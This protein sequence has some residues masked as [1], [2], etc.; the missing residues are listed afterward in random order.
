MVDP[1]KYN[2]S[3][4]FYIPYIFEEFEEEIM[5]MAGKCMD[6]GCGPGYLT[7][8]IL[9][10]ALDPKAVVVSMDISE[11]MIG[12]AKEYSDEERFRF[13]VLDIGTK[14]I[15]EKY[16]DEYDHAFSFHVLQW[17]PD[18]RQAF[19]NIYRL[20]RSGGTILALMFDWVK[21]HKE[22]KTLLKSI[23][24]NVLHCSQRKRS[25]TSEDAHKLPQMLLSF[26]TQF[27]GNMPQVLVEQFKDEFTEEYMRRRFYYRQTYKKGERIL[28]DI[29]EILVVYTQ[30]DNN[31]V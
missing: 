19:E 15:P 2:N 14:H 22:L 27:L 24:F 18:I 7:R 10:S 4:Y 9:L 13:K 3:M 21:P 20:L 1:S 25:I 11:N 17:C 8:Y 16:F 28:S 30:K 5:N 12:H 31:N 6:I 23:G 29:D 26:V